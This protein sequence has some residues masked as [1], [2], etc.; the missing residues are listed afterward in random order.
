MRSLRLLPLPFVSLGE[1][2]VLTLFRPALIIS[3]LLWL[4]APIASHA[5]SGDLDVL[6]RQVEQ[7]YRQGKYAEATKVAEQAL[8]L[9]EKEFGPDHPDVGTTLNNLA[10]LYQRQGRYAAAE[11]LSKR[12]LVITEKALGSDHPSVGTSLNNLALLYMSQRVK[13]RDQASFSQDL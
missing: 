13:R 1:R 4:V 9:A 5:Q 7:F 12:S 2:L 11:L 10:L 8:E 6:N 3:M